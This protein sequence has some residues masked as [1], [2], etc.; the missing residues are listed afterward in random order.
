VTLTDPRD[1]LAEQSDFIG[2]LV[3]LASVGRLVHKLTDGEPLASVREA[4]DFVYALLGL[5]SIG[6]FVETLAESPSAPTQPVAASATVHDRW[7]R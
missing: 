1:A 7:L 2:Y 6:G 3:G 4:D 5:A